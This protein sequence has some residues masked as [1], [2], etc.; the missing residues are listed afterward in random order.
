MIDLT[1]LRGICKILSLQHER[2]GA[3]LDPRRNS[4]RWQVLLVIVVI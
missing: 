4:L 1:R 3:V 2:R